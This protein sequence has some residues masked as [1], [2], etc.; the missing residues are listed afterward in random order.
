M[1]FDEAEHLQPS[2]IFASKLGN[3]SV[4]GT[5]QFTSTDTQNLDLAE[6]QVSLF[7][8]SSSDNYMKKFYMIVL[9]LGQVCLGDAYRFLDNRL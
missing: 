7:R 2:L 4:H 3:L 8:T 6:K 1:R 5:I 9:R